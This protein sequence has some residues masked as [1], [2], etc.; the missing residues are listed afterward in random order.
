MLAPLLMAMPAFAAEHPAR[1][2]IKRG[3]VETRIDPE[4]SRKDAQE[5][6]RLIEHQPDVDLE[7]HARLLLCDYLSERNEAGAQ[8][9]IAKATALMPHATRKGLRA[10]VLT[11]EGETLETAGHNAQARILYEQAVAVAE[12]ARDEEMLAGALFQLGY[13]LGVQ[14]EFAT[15]LSDLRRAQVLYDKLNMP[16]HSLTTLD[17]I[18]ILYNRM[19]DYEQAKHIFTRTLQA[20][21][22]AGMQRE[23]AVTLHNLARAHE[24][25]REWD[26]ARKAFTES[27]AISRQLGYPRGEAYALRGLAAVSIALGDPADGLKTLE[28]ASALLEHT[29]DV[30]LRAQ[31]ELAMGIALHRLHR[32]NESI[33]AL[34]DARDVFRKGGVLGELAATYTEIAGVHAEL[35]NFRA[36]FEMQSEAKLTSEKLLR[37][38]LNQRFATLKVEFD[39]NSKE[40]ENALLTRENQANQKALAQE[41]RVR[42]LQ[43]VVIGLTV[44]LA[45]LL[46]TLAVFQ[47]RNTRRMRRLAMTD[48]LTGVPN[49]RAVLREL[50][51]LLNRDEAFPCS[52]LIIDIDHFKSINDHHGHPA[53]DEVLKVVADKVRGNVHPP[54]CFGRLGG[55]EFLI[56]L[57]GAH[58]EDARTTADL[59]RET[60]SSV[61]TTR[62]FSDRRR[63]TASIGVTTA[64]AVGDTPSSMLQRADGALYLAKRSGR[65]CVKSDPAAPETSDWLLDAQPG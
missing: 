23:Q 33:A 55:E 59:F 14:G 18:A 7:I 43:R 2:L 30:R 19:G 61:D 60:I 56:V 21:R 50:S 13:L 8:Q 38:Q 20:Q 17:S 45:C 39:T 54:A 10:G 5:A 51:S 9:E 63:I 28:R 44:V 11:C 41:R 4:Q 65:N 49:R 29:P 47:A 1:A 16:H 52:I 6:L 22:A 31:I 42:S 12:T 37:N 26:A 64:R 35:G 57:P 27:L 53:G 3:W 58:I 48:E 62:W 25:L 40:K 24:N 34:E 32:L 46:A 36:A 15:G